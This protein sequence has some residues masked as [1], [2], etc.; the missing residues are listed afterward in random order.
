[1]ATHMQW[2]LDQGWTAVRTGANRAG[3]INAP[4][5]VGIDEGAADTIN[6]HFSVYSKRFA[7]G[8][9]RLLQGDNT[10]QNMYGVVIQPA[11][12]TQL[13]VG[14]NFAADEPNGAGSA[15]AA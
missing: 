13:A 14:L 5:E 11:P 3:D 12:K 4:D 9:F 10:G 1:D 15:L 8:T 6:N 7:A 2:I